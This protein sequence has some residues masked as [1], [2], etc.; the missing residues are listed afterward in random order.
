MK[1][2][3]S[4]IIMLVL[5]L[6]PESCMQ[7]EQP[8]FRVILDPGHGGLSMRNKQ[9][10]GDRYDLL[11]GKYLS[12]FQ[13]GASYKGIREHVIVYNISRKV[14]AILDLCAP[15][16]DFARF[17]KILARYTDAE[18]ERIYIAATLSRGDSSKTEELKSRE[19]MNGEFRIYDYPGN[20]GK[21]KP[22][23][24]SRM[25][26]IKPHLVVSLHLANYCDPAF[27]GMNPVIVG[28]YSLMHKGLLYLQGKRGDRDFFKRSRYTDWFHESNRRGSFGWFLK[29]TSVYFTSYPNNRKYRIDATDFKGYRYN[30]VT[31]AYRD[32]DGDRK[33]VV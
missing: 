8:V 30:M 10:N 22:G 16:G 31:W 6:H 28:P 13:E 20:D 17:S 4:A 1:W 18:P 5:L 26:L 3:G 19:N 32:K 14:K 23:R 9:R 12:F 11:S 33:S 29:D 24:I 27:L 25:N 21:I 15:G 2:I 7:S